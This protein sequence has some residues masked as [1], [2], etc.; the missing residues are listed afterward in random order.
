MRK[1]LFFTLLLS[2]PS[3][4]FS[5]YRKELGIMIG[6]T[7]YLGEL[8]GKEKTRRDF[9]LDMKLGQ[10]RD[11]LG[12]YYR[13]KIR[14]R[15]FVSGTFNQ[16][17]LRGAD[18]LSLNPGRNGRRLDFKNNILELA[19][20][21]EYAFYQTNNMKGGGRGGSRKDFRAYVAGGVGVFHSN[22]KGTNAD[23]KWI[24][25]RP[26]GT[27]GQGINGKKVYP[28]WN[29]AIP[30]SAGFN[31][32]LNREIRLGL[33]LGWRTTFTD[34]IDDVSTVYIDTN[35]WSKKTNKAERIYFYDKSDKTGFLS[36]DGGVAA[37]PANY[38][39]DYG[40]GLAQKRGD[41]THKD[42]YMFL[43]VKAGYVFKGKNKFYRNRSSY[44]SRSKYKKR[45]VRAKF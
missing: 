43:Q 36:E 2:F 42:S 26:L 11:N 25:L 20:Q 34:Y 10:T 33:E 29:W 16:G 22:P 9:I 24:E 30:L 35:I 23:G 37:V 5:Q 44:V 8:G 39:Y 12:I 21:G 19:V 13:Y 40:R 17:I 14:P 28:V 6:G 38:G 41:P 1:I 45:K 31:Y 3:L 27:E 32:T 18:T 7:N 15:I 4:V